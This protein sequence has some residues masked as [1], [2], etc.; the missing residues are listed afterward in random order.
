MGM[1]RLTRAAKA[2]GYAMANAEELLVPAPLPKKNEAP[3][4]R[5]AD[6]AT[7]D[8]KG[9]LD[10]SKLSGMFRDWWFAL[11]SRAAASAR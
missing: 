6:P 1:D 9:R 11:S 7:H 10:L 2:A 3:A 8:T 4:W 5:T